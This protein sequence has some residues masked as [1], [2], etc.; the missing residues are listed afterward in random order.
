MEKRRET[1]TAI[2][3]KGKIF[4]P[5]TGAED[6]CV[7]LDFSTEGAGLKTAALA[8]IGTNVVLY[9]ECFGRFEGKVARRNRIRLGIAFQPSGAKRQRTA[10]QIE[11]YVTSGVTRPQ[12]ARGGIR[13][14]DVPL[15]KHFTVA[16]GSQVA[17]EVVNIALG[18]ASLK[19]E[20]KPPLGEVLAFGQTAGRVVRHTSDGIAV[21]F[22][23]QRMV[24]E[25]H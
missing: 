16:D 21:E 6:D 10:R 24:R 9:L 7:V 13:V 20:T 25:A 17:C 1:R 14:S 2:G 11:E 18:G 12:P 5:K 23:G 4:N 15:L 3:L 22:I 19:T 8:P